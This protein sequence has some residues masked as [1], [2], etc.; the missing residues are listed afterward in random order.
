MDIKLLKKAIEDVG[1]VFVKFE[2]NPDSS[3][4]EGICVVHE[5]LVDT[6]KEP[7]KIEKVVEILKQSLPYY[8]RDDKD[9]YIYIAKETDL[10]TAAINLLNEL[11]K[12]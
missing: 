1:I 7:V 8:E 9:A 4:D 2:G 6:T 11:R 10:I 5:K 3:F 12:K